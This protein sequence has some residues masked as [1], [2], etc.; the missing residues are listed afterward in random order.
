MNIELLV[1]I[2]LF[3]NVFIGVLFTLKSRKIWLPYLHIFC[4]FVLLTIGG[5]YS[6]LFNSESIIGDVFVFVV[7]D[8]LWV[9]LFVVIAHILSWI[10]RV[11]PLKHKQQIGWFFLLGFPLSFMIFIH[12]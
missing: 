4:T 6:I 11:I 12:I 3:L 8:I 5:I 10:V 7:G 1:N 2:I 9:L